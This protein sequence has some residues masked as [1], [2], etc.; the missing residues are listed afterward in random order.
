MGYEFVFPPPEEL[1]LRRAK[2]NTAGLQAYLAPVA[3]LL[4]ICF[5]RLTARLIY[6]NGPGAASS[7]AKRPVSRPSDTLT[8]LG[9]RIGWALTTTYV[10]EFGPLYIQCLGAIYTFYLLYAVFSGTGHDYMHLTK[11]LGHVAVSQLPWQYLLAFKSHNSPITLITGLTHE[12]LNAVHRLFGR[13]VHSLLAMHAVLYLNFFV[14]MGNLDKRIKDKDVRLGVIAFWTMNI[15]GILALP[16][17]RRK[18]YHAIFYRSHVLLTAALPIILWFH[19][20]WTRWYLGQALIFWFANGFTGTKNSVVGKVHGTEIGNTGLIETELELE[21]SSDWL[22]KV[23]VPGQ[24]IY[25]MK[26]Q[27]GLGPRNPFTVVGVEEKDGKHMISCVVRKLGAGTKQLSGTSASADFFVEG[28]YGE[29]SQYLPNLLRKENA[30]EH[31]VLVAG[32]VGATYT[33]PIYLALLRAR[34]SSERV[35]MLWIARNR[36]DVVWGEEYLVSQTEHEHNVDVYLTQ[37]SDVARVSSALSKGINVY[38]GSR[39]SDLAEIVESVM[40]PKSERH[41]NTSLVREKTDKRDPRRIKKSHEPVTFLV[42]G[43]PDM[44]QA[45]RKAAGRHVMEYGRDVRWFEEQFGFGG[46]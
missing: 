18:A 29:A 41:Q 43:P 39:R 4:L 32:G 33:I 45:V 3:I 2:L 20:P 38:A 14:R 22:A 19:Q 15:L 11:Q 17:V 6:S 25:L 1:E 37:S 27:G 7:K 42:C 8:V 5:I 44:A 10:P 26:K 9:R 24:H 16:V 35:K 13:I 31:V 28:P 40:A 21:E 36:D 23:W 12:R 46:S 34:K 30:D